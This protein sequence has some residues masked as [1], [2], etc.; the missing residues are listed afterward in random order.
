MDK[1]YIVCFADDVNIWYSWYVKLPET[2]GE[3][4]EYID[5][6]ILKNGN[7]K[8]IYSGKSESLYTLE[9]AEKIKKKLIKYFK[10]NK[11]YFKNRRIFLIKQSKFQKFK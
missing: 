3:L 11:K 4:L 7:C 2:P 9:K 1:K 8:Y 5:Y 6:T 10:N